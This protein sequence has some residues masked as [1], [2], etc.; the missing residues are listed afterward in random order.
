MDRQILVDD[1]ELIKIDYEYVM[2]FARMAKYLN[3][4]YFGFISPEDVISFPYNINDVEITEKL[5]YTLDTIKIAPMEMAP[6]YKIVKK[7]LERDTK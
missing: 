1:E 2:K 6:V 5:P 7:C 4:Q 3:I